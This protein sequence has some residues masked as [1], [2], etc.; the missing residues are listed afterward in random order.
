MIAVQQDM[1]AMPTKKPRLLVV[2]D[3]DLKDEFERLCAIENR[4]MS[5]MLATLA[6]QAVEAAKQQGKLGDRPSKGKKQ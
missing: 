5:N 6:Q 3:N 4:S 2:M 1:S